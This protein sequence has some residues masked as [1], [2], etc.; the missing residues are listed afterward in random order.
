MRRGRALAVV[1]VSALVA[2]M[3]GVGLPSARAAQ[4]TVTLQV[5][6]AS[7]DVVE[8]NDSSVT[9]ASGELN[10]GRGNGSDISD[11]GLR[12]A[13]VP[14]PQGAVIDEAHISITS[15]SYGLEAGVRTVLKGAKVPNI[16]TFSSANRPSQNVKTAASVSWDPPSWSPTTVYNSPDIKAIIQEIVNQPGWAEG[17]ALGIAW[18]DNGT[19][20]WVARYIYSR[21]FWAGS[22]Y[23]PRLSV[24]YS[25]EPGPDLTPPTVRLTS[26]AAGATVSGVVQ[27][28]ADASD[29]RAVAKVD[30][31]VD[32]TTLGSDSS[33]PYTH[34]WDTA[35][36][37]NGPHTVRAVA[38]DAAGNTATDTVSCTV[39]RDVTPPVISE[40]TAT[41]IGARSAT[42]QWRTD[43]PATSQVEYGPTSS[44]GSSTGVD[45]ALVTS[46][47]VV[48]SGLS[49]DSTYHFRVLSRDQSGNAAASSDRVF[50]TTPAPSTPTGPVVSF[51]FDDTHRNQYTE[52]LPRLKARGHVGTVFVV[53]DEVGANDLRLS[54]ADL[55][56][57]QAEGWEISSHSADHLIGSGTSVAAYEANVLRAK[58]WL[59]ANGFPGSGFASPGGA[60]SHNI[61]TGVRKYH[62]YLR[63]ADGVNTGRPFD[64][65][66]LSTRWL[67]AGTS[68]SEVRSWLDAAQRDNAWVVFSAHGVSNAGFDTRPSLLTQISQEVSS[69]GI[70]VLTVR[71]VING[72]YP[73]QTTI[74][75]WVDTQQ[76]PVLT[77]FSNYS[78]LNPNAWNEF[79]EE[80]F[81]YPVVMGHSGNKS[82]PTMRFYRS[83]PNGTYEVYANLAG[84][85]GSAARYYYSFNDPAN[86][87]ARSVDVPAGA[88]DAEYYLGTVTVTNGQFSLY[89]RRTDA[90]TAGNDWYFAWGWV[91]LMK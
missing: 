33:A 85:G 12:F 60:W 2:G 81:G 82:L 66:R 34:P 80:W 17:N 36:Y 18:E 5:A 19:P 69:R 83:V 14:I 89:T 73:P 20:A 54:K 30:F 53:T 52:A 79:W 29:N 35:T 51:A 75:C 63:V 24:T 71:D 39:Y 67:N 49:A 48:L 43:E 28:A 26:P 50:A 8:V 44:Y 61:V 13:A 38:F 42:I 55:T 15:Y 47:E 11:I 57:M 10:V 76:S 40:V 68:M 64:R 23:G 86:P 46:H 77:T 32:G 45:A 62:P 72:T 70:P 58:T 65:Y 9:V 3:L 21:D 74:D 56:A 1:M 37:A 7:D 91:K 27:L 16:A 84:L 59:D 90:L 4:Q 6:A 41:A 25:Y 88:V 31:A 87:L 78:Q 22:Q